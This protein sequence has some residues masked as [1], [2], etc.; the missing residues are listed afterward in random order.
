MSKRRE[1]LIVVAAI[2]ALAVGL[3]ASTWAMAQAGQAAITAGL[4]AQPAPTD[5]C[6]QTALSVSSVSR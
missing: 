6:K 2:M 3:S 4:I 1:M 5:G